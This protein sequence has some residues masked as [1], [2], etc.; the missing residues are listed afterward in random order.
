MLETIALFTLSSRLLG[1][2]AGGVAGGGREAC[3]MV[4]SSGVAAA[5]YLSLS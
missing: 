5:A 1:R 3:L 2:W 4:Y